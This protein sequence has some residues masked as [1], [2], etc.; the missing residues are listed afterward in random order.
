VYNQN[1]ESIGFGDGANATYDISEGAGLNNRLLL[2]NAMVDAGFTPY[3][4]EYWHF[5]YGDIE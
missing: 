1:N 2:L 4:G 5:M 3:Y